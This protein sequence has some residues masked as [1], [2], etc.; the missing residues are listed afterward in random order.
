M[1][2]DRQNQLDDINQSGHDSDMEII[3]TPKIS[4]SIEGDWLV[5]THYRGG[6]VR[7]PVKKLENWLV[8]I[9]RSEL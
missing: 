3:K 4:A 9:F 8:K 7:V 1:T 2:C 5:I 6:S